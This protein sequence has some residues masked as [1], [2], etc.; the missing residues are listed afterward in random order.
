MRLSSAVPG[1]RIIGLGAYRPA[2]ILDNDAVAAK[3]IET[4]D[5]WIRSRVGVGTRHVAGA[6]E[7][8]QDMAT[9]AGGK[10]LAA[11]GIEAEEV[12]LVIVATCTL[13]QTIT[14]AAATVGGR[15]G[16]GRPGAFDLNGACAGFC[17]GLSVAQDAIRGGSARTVLLV[18]SERM[19]DYLD[20][21]DR[22]TSIIFG[23]GAGAAVL[24]GA[25][26]PQIGPVV[27]GSDGSKGAAIGQVAGTNK[28]YMD[29][30]PVF[31]WA[32]GE[33]G[34]VA[35]QA[36]ER[37]GVAPG[38]LGAIVPHQA[39]LRIIESIARQI[40]APGAAVGRDIVDSGNTSSASIPLA[41]TRLI[42][43]GEV[44]S[45][46][47]VLVVGFGAGLTYAGQVITCP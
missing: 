24:T 14:N 39:N 37:A 46:Q 16:V 34:K 20:W 8:V 11:A 31:R 17:Y 43:R 27:W 2:Q 25:D 23:D 26:E 42:E 22:S 1:A 29:G 32:T 15:L 5:E 21:H 10:A 41:L 4:S 13:E 7:S 19:T 28:M 44:G 9:A 18:G 38:D 47:A 35:L 6:G 45:G 30:Q 3:G 33:M 36:C 40:G 12:D